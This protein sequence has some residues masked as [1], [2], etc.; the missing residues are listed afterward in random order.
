[1]RVQ[2]AAEHRRFELAQV[3]DVLS[4]ALDSKMQSLDDERIEE[5]S[6]LRELVANVECPMRLGLNVVMPIFCHMSH[7]VLPQA[8]SQHMAGLWHG[9]IPPLGEHDDVHCLA[10][11]AKRLDLAAQAMVFREPSFDEVA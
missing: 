1:M 7:H 4:D 6:V 10:S 2:D 9:Q 3:L 8:V 11:Q 5:P